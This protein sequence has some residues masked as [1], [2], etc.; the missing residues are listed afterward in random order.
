MGT[1]AEAGFSEQAELLAVTNPGRMVAGDTPLIVPAI[2][3]PKGE[4]SFWER[5]LGR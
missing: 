3:M 4:R 1:L 5:V 2:E